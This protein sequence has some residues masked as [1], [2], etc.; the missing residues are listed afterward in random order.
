MHWQGQAL[1]C[2]AGLN[3][4]SHPKDSKRVRIGMKTCTFIF[5][6]AA[7]TA[8]A[9]C[10][11]PE[12]TRPAAAGLDLGQF[13]RVQLILTDSVNTSYAKTGLPMFE[14]LL[15]GRLQSL[16]FTLVETNAEMVLDVTVQEFSPGN[17]TMRTLVGFGAGR[18]ILNYTAQFKNPGGKILAQLTGGKVYHGLEARDNPTFKSDEATRMGLISYSVSEIGDF[19]EHR[20]QL[21]IRTAP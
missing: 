21:T 3:P 15:K 11:T 9:G 13:N 7:A 10:V 17:R 6:V 4:G 2:V 5:C 8:L 16:G 12:A 19:T 18:A 20:S 1:E 14:G